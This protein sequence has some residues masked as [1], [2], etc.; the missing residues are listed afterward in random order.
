VAFFNA[1]DQVMVAHAVVSMLQLRTGGIVGV[2]EC[3]CS[4]GEGGV[5][6]LSQMSP[7][8]LYYVRNQSII[9]GHVM[10]RDGSYSLLTMTTA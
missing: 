9:A 8:P 1:A 5:V 4:C 10:S 2:V 6:I 7:H 3:V